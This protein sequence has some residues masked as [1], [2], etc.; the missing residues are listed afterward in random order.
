MGLLEAALRRAFGL[1]RLA[2]AGASGLVGLGFAL[3]VVFQATRTAQGGVQR[4]R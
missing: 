3:V 2:V 1:A 4:G